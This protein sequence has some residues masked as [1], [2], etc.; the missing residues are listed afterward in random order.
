[1]VHSW[2]I[3]IQCLHNKLKLSSLVSLRSNNIGLPGNLVLR[4]VT[5]LHPRVAKMTDRF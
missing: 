1:M 5:A 4:R 2:Q 3:E